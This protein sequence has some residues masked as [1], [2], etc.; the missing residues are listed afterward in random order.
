MPTDLPPRRPRGYGD[1][2]PFHS[3]ETLL[4][5]IAVLAFI[6]TGLLVSIKIG[7]LQ[8]PSEF[9]GMLLSP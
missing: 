6:V 9:P 1:N 8:P 4:W 7:V 3:R 2:R 5:Q